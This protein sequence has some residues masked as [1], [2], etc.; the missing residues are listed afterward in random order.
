MASCCTQ[1]IVTGDISE[2]W[3]ASPGLF[4]KGLALVDDVAYFGLSER[5]EREARDSPLNECELAAF[6]MSA[7]KL[8]WRRQVGGVVAGAHAASV[9][10]SAPC[11][12]CGCPAPA[13]VAVMPIILCR[14]ISGDG[15]SEARF[16]SCSCRYPPP[17]QLPTHG[18]LNIIAAP[19]L[20]EQS[21]YA[22]VYSSPSGY[23]VAP[24]SAGLVD[25]FQQYVLSSDYPTVVT[26]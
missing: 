12:V 4:L 20:G 8:L 1:D 5:A 14:L 9:T 25:A 24:D 22:A 26:A 7:G 18:L 3:R 2:L 13:L 16:C 6:D 10:R 21:T 11:S 19:Q 17:P 23:L 15:L